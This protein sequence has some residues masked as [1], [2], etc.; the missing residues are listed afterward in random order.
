MSV[1][2][3]GAIEFK[4]PYGKW[5][6]S[7][8]LYTYG[9]VDAYA[10]LAFPWGDWEPSD[11]LPAPIIKPKGLPSDLSIQVISE[12]HRLVVKNPHD[13]GRY[14]SAEES[15]GWAQ[16]EFPG[17]KLDPEEW[18]CATWLTTEEMVQVCAAYRAY[19]NRHRGSPEL[20]GALAMMRALEDHGPV[21]DGKRTA[22][23]IVLWF[24]R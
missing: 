16:S 6:A 18:C 23:R 5:W 17:Y 1:H 22:A 9:D 14:C 24:Q 2:G 19:K 4:Y 8:K 10:L 11:D 15:E 7:A 20:E 21:I 12:T 3:R 13:E